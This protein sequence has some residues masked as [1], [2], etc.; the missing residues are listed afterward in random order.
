M[1]HPLYAFAV[2]FYYKGT[3]R[4]TKFEKNV[5]YPV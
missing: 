5:L 4:Y 3:Q 2:S 1:S